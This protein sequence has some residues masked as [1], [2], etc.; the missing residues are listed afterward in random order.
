MWSSS[1]GGAVPTHVPSPDQLRR[2][3]LYKYDACAFC[4]RV[5]QALDRLGLEVELRDTLKDADHRA[6]LRELTGGTQVPCLLID[7]EPLLESADIVAWLQAY[8]TRAEE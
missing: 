2:L 8:A 6:A 4:R 5:F 7:D 1:R 3:V